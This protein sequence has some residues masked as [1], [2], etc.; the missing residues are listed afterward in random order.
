MKMVKPISGK[1]EIKSIHGN[2][3][4]WGLKFSDSTGLM[5]KKESRKFLVTLQG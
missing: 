1:V 2:P 3:C 4:A 5:A